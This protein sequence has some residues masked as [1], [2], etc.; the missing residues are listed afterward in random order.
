MEK[1]R[2]VI[3]SSIHSERFKYVLETVFTERLQIPFLLTTD[4]Q[5]IQSS[6]IVIEY[7]FKRKSEFNFI[8]A[9]QIIDDIQIQVEEKPNVL[10][11]YE[12]FKLYPDQNS[13]FGMDIF[14]A[15]FYCLSHYDAYLQNEFDVHHRIQFK[16]WYPRTSGLDKLPYVDIWI[17]QLSEYIESYG[18]KCFTSEFQQDISFDIDHIYLMDQ[19][20]IM[21]HIRASIGDLFRL[22]FFQ[23]FQRWLIILGVTEDPAEKFFDMLDYKSTNKFSFFILMKEG[24]HNSL[25][26]LNELKKLLIKKLKNHGSIALHPSYD[27]SIKRDLISKEKK[28]L[29]EIILEEVNTSR[30]HFL[31]MQ[32]P[33]SFYYLSQ[34]GIQVDKS[35]GYYDQ[36]G[37][38]SSTS[39]SYRF[40]DPV[41]NQIIPITISPFVW[42]DSMN[43]YY[44]T[45]DEKEEKNELFAL[46][47][48]VKKY[49][50]QFNVVFHNDS[51][52]YRRYRLLFKSLLYN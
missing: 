50:G 33:T 7:N 8:L 37:F 10:G 13:L 5:Q 42:M 46:K 18:L 40:F 22:R 45:I 28:Q 4:K 21:K 44:R 34:A 2:V 6:D 48:M 41:K 47:S 24:K 27:A 36:P 9:N 20:P 49:N 30:F 43:K 11:V 39:L 51:M 23:L 19:R 3:F 52:I 12:D 29:E 15:I 38:P 1:Q 17:Q 35:I 31:R 26:P 32:F 25:N 16:N 14:S